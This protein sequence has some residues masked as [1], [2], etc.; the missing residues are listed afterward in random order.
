MPVDYLAPWILT[1]PLPARLVS[2]EFTSLDQVADVV[3]L[4]APT[5]FERARRATHTAAS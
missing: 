2:I 3:N 4:K 5:V 1:R